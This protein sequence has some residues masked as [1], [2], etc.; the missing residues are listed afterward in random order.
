MMSRY[1]CRPSIA[2]SSHK[3]FTLVELAIVMV[4]IGVLLGGLIIPLTVQQDASKRRETKQLLQDVHDALL[5]FAATNGRLP[6]PATAGSAGLAAP[7]NA[8]NACNTYSGFVPARTLGLAGRVDGNNL[9]IDR[10]LNPIRYNLSSAGGGAYS[11]SI[12]LG[13]TP[14]LEIC[15]NAAC[16]TPLADTVVAVIFAQASDTNASADQLENTDGDTRFVIRT[17]S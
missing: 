2:T 1:C 5:G 7:N 3:G 8:T 17:F 6:C 15:P 10:W 14:D 9:L 13:L 4:V 12:T 11:N 16:G